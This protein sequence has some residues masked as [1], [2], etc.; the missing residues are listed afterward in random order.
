ML[1]GSISVVG[2]HYVVLLDAVNSQ[3][4]RHDCECAVR[5]RRQGSGFE[6]P[7]ARRP[8]SCAR[9]WASTLPPSKVL[10]RRSRTSPPLRLRRCVNIRSGSSRTRKLSTI[11]RFL[12]TRPRSK[13]IPALRSRTRG[14]PSVTTI[15]GKTRLR[16]RNSLRR[17]NCATGSANASDFLSRPIITAARRVSGT[18]RLRNWRS[19]RRPTRTTSNL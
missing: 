15:N 12:F 3:D 14:W 8:R 11:M 10:M 5:S 19:G 18:S 1:L 6:V 4:W 13:K 16:A 9:S 2:S 7:R 17:T